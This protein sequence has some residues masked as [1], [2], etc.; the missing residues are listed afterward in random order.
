[1]QNDLFPKNRTLCFEFSKYFR[2]ILKIKKCRFI[3]LL[4]YLEKYYWHKIII[5]FDNGILFQ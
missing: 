2:K 5:F 1:M 3:Y 4:N